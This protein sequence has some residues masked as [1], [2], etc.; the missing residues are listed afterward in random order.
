MPGEPKI[1]VM[2][3][4]H[5]EAATIGRVVESFRAQLPHAAVYVFDNCSTDATAAIASARGAVV[6]P[7]PRL[8]KG[9]VVEAMLDRIEADYYVMVDGD[10]TYPAAMAGELLAPV[11]SGHADMVVGARRAGQQD[12]P[13]RPLHAAGNSVVRW[14]INRIFSANLTDILSGFRA[15]NARVARSMPVV[16]SGFEVETEMT[17]QAL[18]LRLKILEVPVTYRGRPEG[19]RSKL[20]TFRDGA[21]VLWKVFSLM[22]AFKPLTFFG[23]CGLVLLA[24]AVICGVGPIQDYLAT[25]KVPRFPRAILATGLMILSAMSVF[26]GLLLHAI[27]WRMKELHNVVTRGRR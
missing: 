13:F 3:P 8:G 25:G 1:A 17:V 6:I 5:N 2:I 18:Y 10:D 14:L 9:Y 15:F 22:R 23:G 26:L 19:S 24:L 4:C 16:S 12:K 7:E 11:M 20:R 27:N 21:R